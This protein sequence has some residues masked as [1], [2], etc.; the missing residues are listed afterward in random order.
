ML[1]VI[2]DDHWTAESSTQAC[3]WLTVSRELLILIDDRDKR[4][5]WTKFVIEAAEQLGRK[6]RGVVRRTI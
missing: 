5:V 4:D 2:R 1:L 6:P 3:I